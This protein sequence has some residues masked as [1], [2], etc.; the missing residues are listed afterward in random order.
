MIAPLNFFREKKAI[1]KLVRA[2]E[3]LTEY[4]G[5]SRTYSVGQI[6][7]GMKEL[8]ISKGFWR[9]GFA[10]YLSDDEHKDYC[11]TIGCTKSYYEI[12]G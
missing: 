1:K 3:R 7:R 4:Y 2:S 5:K 12:R 10:M 9:L 6:T 11:V 8:K